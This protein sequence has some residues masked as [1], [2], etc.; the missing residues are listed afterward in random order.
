[1]TAPQETL[2]LA[3]DVAGQSFAP[4]PGSATRRIA[5]SRIEDEIG[6]EL[7]KVKHAE[8]TMIEGKQKIGKLLSHY[9]I[10]LEHGEFIDG[11]E[12]LGITQRTCLNWMNGKCGQSYFSKSPNDQAHL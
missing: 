8:R 4:A 1:M 3:Q 6:D 5:I 10:M 12:G 2:E 7:E 9:K 11:V